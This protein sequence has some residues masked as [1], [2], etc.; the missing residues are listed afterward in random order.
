MAKF[1]A[2]QGF[3]ISIAE[4]DELGRVNPE[5]IKRL[6]RP[7][8]ILVSVMHANNETGTIQPIAEISAFVRKHGAIM[9]CDAAQSVGKIPVNVEE[10]GVDLLSVAGHKLYAPKGIGALYI[11]KGVKIEKL[12]HGADHEQNLRAGTENVLEIVGLGKACEIA[13]E[14][15]EEYQSHTKRLKFKLLR[16]L[17]EKLGPLHINGPREESLPNTLSIGFGNLDALTILSAMPE[18]AASAG[19]A[20]HTGDTDGSGVLG[21]MK[22]SPEFSQG[23]IRFSLGR[24]TTDAEIEEAGKIISKTILSL[25]T[26]TCSAPAV[27]IDI[28]KIKLTQFAH[29]MGCGCKLRPAVLEKV[30]ANLPPVLDP[31]VMVGA[32]K[33]DDAAVYRLTADLALVQTVDFFTPVVDDPYLFGAIAAANSMSDVY[34]MGAKP[35]FALNITAFPINRLPVEVLHEIIRGATDKAAEAGIYVLGGHSIEDNEP[36]FGMVV[37]GLCH[38]DKVLSNDGAKPG[39]VMILTKPIGNGI[40]ASAN[41]MGIADEETV[42]K[43]IRWMA[44]LNAAAAKEMDQFEVSACTDVTGF[45]LIGHLHE[46][47]Q[48]SGVNASLNFK[49]IP[50]MD[51][52]EALVMA[53]AVSGGS[54]ANTENALT[55]TDFG[56]LSQNERFMICDAQTSGGLLVFLQP[57]EA[58]KYMAALRSNDIFHAVIGEI[59]GTGSGLIKIDY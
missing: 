15:L 26:D 37:S 24:H 3:E 25:R 14:K 54:R 12:M 32:D 38:P 44:M 56:N 4:V 50:F 33:K 49:K 8:T 34:A 5:T 43:S 10:M 31:N 30:L 11:R 27:P 57:G 48:A 17:E 16:E 52:V 7:E 41:K 40:I 20:C 9:H 39:D 42:A 2:T 22:V 21:A 36:K 18:I 29:G 51:D 13:K 28:Q 58:E 35:I 59:T 53:G 47:T 6:L 46:V 19:A 45:G 55:W 1:L 23:T